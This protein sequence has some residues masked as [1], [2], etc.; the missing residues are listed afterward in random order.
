MS[1]LVA[2]REP[3]KMRGWTCACTIR[4]ALSVHREV[5]EYAQSGKACR[6]SRAFLFRLTCPLKQRSQAVQDLVWG[7]IGSRAA[8]PLG[9]LGDPTQNPCSTNTDL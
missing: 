9:P 6:T 4:F 5:H 3:S 2:L 1:G 8:V 7:P